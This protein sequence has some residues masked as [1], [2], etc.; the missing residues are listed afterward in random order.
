MENEKRIV[1][2]VFP[3]ALEPLGGFVF[4]VDGPPRVVVRT[5]R[6]RAKRSGWSGWTGIKWLTQP[7]ARHMIS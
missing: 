7:P 5:D 3:I 4:L 2:R 1:P 6:G